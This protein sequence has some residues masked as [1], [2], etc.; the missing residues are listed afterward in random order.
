M[1][2]TAVGQSRDG[3]DERRN[4]PRTGT[5]LMVIFSGVC[6]TITGVGC[7]AG[8]PGASVSCASNR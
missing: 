2:A 3:E 1:R 6:S 4:R 8:V 7:S 5:H